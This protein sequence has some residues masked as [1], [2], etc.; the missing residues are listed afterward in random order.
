MAIIPQT[1]PGTPKQ[2]DAQ[3]KTY[4][5][6][7]L[8]NP[9]A[10]QQGM[11]DN[12][13][14]W[15]DIGRIG[16]VTD[17]QIDE[18]VGK[19]GN[20]GLQNSLSQYK[21]GRNANIVDTVQR[22]VGGAGITGTATPVDAT[23]VAAQA[24]AAAPAQQ[25]QAARASAAQAR[26][27]ADETMEG[28]ISRLVG[29]TDTPWMQ[30]AQALAVERMNGRGLQSS[31]IAAGEGARAAIDAAGQIAQN[32]SG[33]YSQTRLE[34]AR[35]ATQAELANAN[36]ETNT[37]QFNAGESNRVSLANADNAT[38]VGLANAENA[39]QVALANAKTLNDFKM[40]DRDFAYDVARGFVDNDFKTQYARLQSQLDIETGRQLATFEQG[41]RDTSV[42]K[43]SLVQVTGKYSDLVNIVRTDP[44]LDAATKEQV[45]NDLR[46]DWVEE[47]TRISTIY[48]FELPADYMPAVEG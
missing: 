22:A 32:D 17:A 34:N 29:N 15:G 6:Q 36:N 46:S 45:I 21:S 8:S 1:L 44:N 33:I 35:M 31:S 10:F 27:N 9:A 3:L 19:S 30:R 2:T 40:Q 42:G 43:S 25:A 18:Y 37:S 26:V 23:P 14:N 48:N 41:L 11:T 4:F 16:G 7:N 39:T 13:L 12:G 24:V 38:R 47:G 28:I 20:A 5:E